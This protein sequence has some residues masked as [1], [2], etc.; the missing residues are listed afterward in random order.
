MTAEISRQL[1]GAVLLNPSIAPMITIP[2]DALE[3]ANLRPVL[4]AIRA[5]VAAG[6]QFDAVV[7]GE[8]MSRSKYPPPE[9][10]SWLQYVVGIAH[11]T[12]ATGTTFEAYQRAVRE[13][14]VVQQAHSAMAQALDSNEISSVHEV[15]RTLAALELTETTRQ[16]PIAEVIPAVIERMDALQ[17]NRGMPG[18]STGIDKLDNFLGG[19][20]A[21]DLY[22]V[23]GRP[24]M[25][26][27]AL[28]GSIALASPAVPMGIISAEQPDHQ[29]VSRMAA[30]IGGID[31]H[32]MRLGTLDDAD[33]ANF[34]RATGQL[35]KHK[36]VFDDT[37]AP[38]IEHV[39]ATARKWRFDY[40]IRVLFVDY[41]Q[42]MRA[43][44]HQNRQGEV[45]AIARGLKEIAKD[46][47]IAVVAL[48]QINRSVESRAD[49]RPMMADLRDSGAIEQEADTVMTLYRPA[50]YD[51]EHPRPWEA[52]VCIMKN[53]HGPA[54]AT[55]VVE[56]DGKYLRWENPRERHGWSLQKEKTPE[57][58]N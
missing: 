36:L 6:R 24:A 11:N 25:G 43:M 41:I 40:G 51:K 28:M 39:A 46:N 45:E 7:I 31:S 48:A 10:Q 19:L 26:K 35:A 44:G 13:A 12:A 15:V 3:D 52:E 18:V 29:I 20:V 34:A 33:W 5:Y 47:D 2:E 54:P 16:R 17:S 55:A 23:A 38:T 58:E 42:R 14:W 57:P 27:T 9:D 49:K 8:A 32:K 30:Q 4:R 21:S 37:S 1:I 50:V 53:R 22:V 56:F